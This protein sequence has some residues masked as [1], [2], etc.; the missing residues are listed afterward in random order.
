MSGRGEYQ[1]QLTALV[2]A[3]KAND[4]TLEDI[5]PDN[6][7]EHFQE[8]AEL[9]TYR[10]YIKELEDREKELQTAKE[11]LTKNL[12]EKQIE[13][14]NLPAEYQVMR[15]DLQQAQRQIFLYKETSDDLQKRVERYRHQLKDIVDKQQADAS[16]AGKIEDL[17]TQIEDQ[18]TVINKL[19][20]DNRKSEAMFE[21]L[22]ES[23]TKALKRK[24]KQLAKKDKELTEKEE[25]L[26]KLH[27]QVQ[28]ANNVKAALDD[29]NSLLTDDNADMETLV[30]VLPDDSLAVW[31]QNIDLLQQNLSLVEQHQA[32]EEHHIAVKS[33]LYEIMA[34]YEY[35]AA[36]DCKAQLFAAAVSETKTL[37]RFYKASFD[38]LDSFAKAFHSPEADIPSLS[39]ITA[40]LD[41]AQ[42]ALAGYD[43]VKKV[44][45]AITD[46]SGNDDLDQVAFCKELD[47]LAA[48]AADSMSSLEILHNGLWSF[49]HQLSGDP[50]M[51]SD[52][53]GALC[54]ADRVRVVDIYSCD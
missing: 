33:Q 15:V 23:D 25:M 51:L 3:A 17:Q 35:A 40:Q 5:L 6:L 14:D 34:T 22:R 7:E 31:E 29:T 1:K 38:V 45:R 43:S 11:I 16:A 27:Q 9:E 26:A 44:V 28:E 50:K 20:D 4:L 39:Y 52:L 30:D 54:D 10:K 2:A 46:G 18:Q 13:I 37:N 12:D 48:S 49:L 47:S 53:N 41:T 42:E 32:L 8:M 21:Q 24:D 36:Q 19:M